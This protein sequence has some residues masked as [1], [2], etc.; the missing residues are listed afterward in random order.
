MNKVFNLCDSGANSL[1]LSYEATDR[2]MRNQ[3][4]SGY[5]LN[6]LS[7]FKLNRKVT[8]P[9]VTFHEIPHPWKRYIFILNLFFPGIVIGKPNVY[10]LQLRE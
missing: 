9:L 1:P 2:M 7:L 4:K 10:K 6:S 3:R 5:N 8:H